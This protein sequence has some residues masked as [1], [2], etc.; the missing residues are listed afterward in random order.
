MKIWTTAEEAELLKKRFAKENRAKFAREH[1]LA[2]GDSMVYQHITGRRPIS[3]EAA[4]DYARAFGCSLAEISPRLALEV[5]DVA[6]R[7]AVQLSGLPDSQPLLIE[8]NAVPEIG[9]E[10]AEVASTTMNRLTDDELELVHLYRDMEPKW[11]EML[12]S[13]AKKSPKRL[14][15]PSIRRLNKN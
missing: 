2:G 13:S 7:A 15:K 11:R 8:Q 4:L 3:L 5:N 6:N 12:M 9:T 10:Q 1:G 14:S